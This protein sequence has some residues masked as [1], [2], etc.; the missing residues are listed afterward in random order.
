M[1]HR[2]LVRRDFAL[3]M[4]GHI[5]EIREFCWFSVMIRETENL[6]LSFIDVYLPCGYSLEV[7]VT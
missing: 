3:L 6:C 4:G 2:P 7:F 5:C 1:P